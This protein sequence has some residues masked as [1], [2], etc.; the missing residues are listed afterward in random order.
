MITVSV[1]Q[2]CRRVVFWYRTPKDLGFAAH[3]M[4]RLAGTAN[5]FAA[6]VQ[7]SPGS[8]QELSRAPHKTSSP[9]RL[10]QITKGML[11]SASPRSTIP[12][13]LGL[14]KFLPRCGYVT[15]PDHYAFWVELQSMAVGGPPLWSKTENGFNKI[16]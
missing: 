5:G 7:D 16:S 14:R 6:Y 9:L 13:Y 1:S 11:G 15:Y 10:P 3:L 2:R 4:S 8:L 12:T